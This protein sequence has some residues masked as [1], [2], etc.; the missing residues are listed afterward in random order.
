MLDILIEVPVCYHLS[1]STV[2]WAVIKFLWWCAGFLVEYVAGC[3]SV[4]NAGAS[5]M[6]GW[7]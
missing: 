1:V 3:T 7:G 6:E 5:F 4:S 2:I